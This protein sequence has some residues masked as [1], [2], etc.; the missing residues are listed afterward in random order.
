L[1]D[2]ARRSLAFGREKTRLRA[3]AQSVATDSDA[4]ELPA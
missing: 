3:S 4:W 1:S 2:A